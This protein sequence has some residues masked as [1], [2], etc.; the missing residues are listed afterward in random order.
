MCTGVVDHQESIPAMPTT[1]NVHRVVPVQI[2]GGAIVNCRGGIDAN[3]VNELFQEHLS[4]YFT[5]SYLDSLPADFS[6]FDLTNVNK[7]LVE[8][9]YDLQ[10]IR[11]LKVKVVV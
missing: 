7:S 5:F 6:Q 4:N 11:N 3:K 10:Q 8:L 2:A 9:R 1:R